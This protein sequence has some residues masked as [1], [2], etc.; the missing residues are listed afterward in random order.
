LINSRRQTR[1]RST[2]VSNSREEQP[3]YSLCLLRA[4]VFAFLQGIE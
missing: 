3:E 2:A 1:R 4:R